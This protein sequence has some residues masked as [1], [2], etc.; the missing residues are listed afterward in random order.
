MVIGVACLPEKTR[1]RLHRED[2]SPERGAYER[3]HQRI[4]HSA[5]FRRLAH[6]TQVYV[7]PSADHVRTRLTHTIEVAQIARSIA[8]RLGLCE[9]LAEAVA[10]AHD[11]GHPPF[12]HVGEQ[13]L[14]RAL[15]KWGG[16][17]S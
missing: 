9:D 11:I 2:E 12:G 1:G 14:N 17:D 15:S 5:A 6:K 4:L 3:D 13:S 7:D 8:R 16:F 10:L